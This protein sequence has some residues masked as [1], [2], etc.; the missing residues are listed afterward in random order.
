MKQQELKDYQVFKR[1]RYI[2]L[3]A[4]LPNIKLLL[5]IQ[6]IAIFQIFY[7]PMIFMGQT[8]DSA[9]TLGLLIYKLI[10]TTQDTG[11]AAAL[12]VITMIILLG[13]TYVYL[14]FDKRTN[15]MVSKAKP[16]MTYEELLN[17]VNQRQEKGWYKVL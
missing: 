1:L 17:R 13:F 6:I 3:P 9:N 2:T 14:Y 8:N 7:E 4:L 5:I 16:Y 10:Y 11:Q 15:K 12:G